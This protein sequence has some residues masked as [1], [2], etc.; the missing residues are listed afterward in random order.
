MKGNLYHIQDAD[1]PMWVVAKNWIAAVDSWK[2]FIA[3]ENS[4]PA[5]EVEECHGITLMCDADDLII[6]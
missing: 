6:E 4:Q 5:E 2:R 3:E 1:R